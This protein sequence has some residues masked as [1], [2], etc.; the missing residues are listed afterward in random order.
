MDGCAD[1]LFV[2]LQSTVHITING[3]SRQRTNVSIGNWKTYK[4]RRGQGDC[5]KRPETVMP[6]EFEI[7]QSRSPS[8]FSPS[9]KRLRVSSLRPRPGE[10]KVAK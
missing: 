6:S 7:I 8:P 3:A 9:R 4:T 2:E 1:F 10:N 5:R